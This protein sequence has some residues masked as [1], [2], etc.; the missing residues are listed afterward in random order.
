MVA[1]VVPEC[2][3]GEVHE[4]LVDELVRRLLALPLVREGHALG[5]AAAGEVA[6][7]VLGAAEDQRPH[8]LARALPQRAL[9][10]LL[11]GLHPL[12]DPAVVLLAQRADP[13]A[14]RDEAAA[15]GHKR[16]PGVRPLP[17]GPVCGAGEAL[18]LAREPLVQRAELHAVGLSVARDR[19][20]VEIKSQ[21]RGPQRFVGPLPLQGCIDGLAQGH[22]PPHLVAVKAL[23]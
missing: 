5:A 14:G 7:E 11:P 10:A 13:R 19:G 9:R 8:P 1:V 21:L 15:G 23:P 6:V 20:L 22:H 18:L 17:V 3:R 4:P 12:A 2:R 16:A